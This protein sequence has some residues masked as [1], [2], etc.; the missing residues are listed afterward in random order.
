M[1]MAMAMARL[2]VHAS[3]WG[4]FAIGH[5]KNAILAGGHHSISNLLMDT[6]LL[7]IFADG[8]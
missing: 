3:I 8:H 2:P 4:K 7:C 1:A 5:Y 6:T